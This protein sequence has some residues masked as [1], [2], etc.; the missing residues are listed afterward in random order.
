LLSASGPPAI[1]APQ[2]F[3]IQLERLPVEFL[4][5]QPDPIELAGLLNAGGEVW[6]PPRPAS[7]S[8][9]FPSP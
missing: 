1:V 3:G 2:M 8:S 9:N 5:E 4:H 6:T 7:R